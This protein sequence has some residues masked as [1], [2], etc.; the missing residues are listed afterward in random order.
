MKLQ[1]LKVK[2]LL[3]LLNKTQETAIGSIWRGLEGMNINWKF[4]PLKTNPF[5]IDALYGYQITCL[6]GFSS[7][8][9]LIKSLDILKFS[10]ELLKQIESTGSVASLS[11][12]TFYGRL[13]HFRIYLNKYYLWGI[14]NDL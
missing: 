11:K 12:R 9:K 2:Q 13:S 14:N 6:V 3:I 7:Q 10:K 4:D 8:E 5:I 1:K